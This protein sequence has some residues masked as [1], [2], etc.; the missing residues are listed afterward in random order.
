MHQAIGQATRSRAK[1]VWQA[2]QH[3]DSFPG[4]H[5]VI[6]NAWPYNRPDDPPQ[7]VS[8]IGPY[9]LSGKRLNAQNR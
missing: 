9:G 7:E 4:V 2:V 8:F 5:E 3:P 6:N 1:L